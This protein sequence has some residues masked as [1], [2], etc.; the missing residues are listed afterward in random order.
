VQVK[1]IR[2]VILEYRVHPEP[3]SLGPDGRPC[4]RATIGLLQRRPVRVGAIVYIGKESNA[5][6]V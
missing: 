3:K 4:G 5:L 6:V 2:D 1:S